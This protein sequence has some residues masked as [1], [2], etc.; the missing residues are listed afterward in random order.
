MRELPNRLRAFVAI[1]LE[2]ETLGA[3]ENFV[4]YQRAQSKG[5]GW[6]KRGNLHVTLRFLGDS[7][8]GGQI[9]Q[10]DQAISQIASETPRFDL[11]ARGVGAFPNFTR[12]RTVWIGIHGDALAPLAAR[13]EDSARDC[14]FVPD[15]RSYTPHLAIGRVRDPR[16]AASIRSALA[17]A[18]DCEFGSSSVDWIALYRSIVGAGPTVYEELARYKLG[19]PA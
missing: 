12:P 7:V 6:V 16:Q 11:Q 19:T 9:L 1:R 17:D 2:N 4:E 15:M 3:I 5:V 14:A 8:A 13:I 18:T 10:L